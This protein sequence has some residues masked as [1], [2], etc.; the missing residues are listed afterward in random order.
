MDTTSSFWYLKNLPL[1]E[2][3]K[4]YVMN[5]PLSKIPAGQRTNQVCQSYPNISVKD[6]RTTNKPPT[7]DGNGFCLSQSIPL[8][9]RYEDFEDVVKFKNVYCENVKTAL[10]NL[11]GAESAHVV[12]QA[13]RRRHASFP[14]EPRGS[15]EAITD[16]PVQG[17][18]CDYTPRRVYQCL[19]EVFGINK[20]NE[21]WNER[22]VQIM[23]VWRPLRG[24]VVDWPLGVCDSTSVDSNHDLVAT[25]NVWSYTV[26]ES[27]NV[28][29]N[30][31]H[32][33]YYVSNQTSED[34]LLFKGF[35][36][37]KGVSTFCPHAAFE[38]NTG[39][40]VKEMRESV[41]CAI[42]LIYPK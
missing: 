6:I 35:D 22:R 16:Q 1:Y 38:L 3:T 13:I 25:D 15:R 40:E 17:V 33:W 30:S 11:T 7:L 14:E 39:S 36:N 9:L 23:Q 5:L 24:P 10:L 2:Q 32:S 28:F 12:H 20:A 19:R 4:P 18:H 21:I 26:A 37:A 27:Y 34:V 41:E 8:F 29:Y 31:R 42:L